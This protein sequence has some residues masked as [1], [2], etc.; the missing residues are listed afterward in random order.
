MAE[1][2]VKRSLRLDERI[3][4]LGLILDADGRVR[5]ETNFHRAAGSMDEVM[6][7]LRAGVV[8]MRRRALELLSRTYDLEG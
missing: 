1:T 7:H 2:T 3:L 6:D 4:N 8:E 5:V